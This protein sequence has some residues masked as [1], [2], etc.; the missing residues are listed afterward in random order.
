[1]KVIAAP[2]A[3][4]SCRACGQRHDPMLRC[5]RFAPDPVVLKA[6]VVLIRPVVLKVANTEPKRKPGKY[7][8]AEARREYK[9]QWLAKRRKP[10]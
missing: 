6:D 7:K 10:V 4:P 5:E 1:M 3:F 2:A 8:D 9:R